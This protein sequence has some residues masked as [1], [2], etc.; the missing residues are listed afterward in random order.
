MT[1]RREV[2]RVSRIEQ[3]ILLIRG[4]KVIIDADLAEFYGLSTKRL[5]EQMK[6]NKSRFPDDFVFRLTTKEKS[7]VVAKCD[8]LSNLKY[9]NALPCAFTEHGALMEAG[10]L[11]TDRAVEVS[12]F[13]V[14]AFVKLRQTISPHK[15]LS[16]NLAQLE[17][18]LARHDRQIISLVHAIRSLTGPG[19]VPASRRIGFGD[20]EP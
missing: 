6:R 5:N 14:R 15:E 16:R 19:E 11:N 7:E 2:V 4:V 10:V 1:V 9:S 3:R 20:Q 17:K 18:K 13:V 8:H 12:V